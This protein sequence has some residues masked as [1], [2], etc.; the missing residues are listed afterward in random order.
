MTPF[1]KSGEKAFVDSNYVEM[2]CYTPGAEIRYT[3]DGTE[4]SHSSS[5]YTVPFYIHASTNFKIKAFNTG[6]ET[7]FTEVAS[8]LKLPYKRSIS[9]SYPYSHLY[10][11]GGSNGLIDGLHGEPEVFG[12]WQ[13]FFGDD[14]EAVIDLGEPRTFSEISSTYLQ[15]YLAWIWIPESVVYSISNNGVDFKEVYSE[16]GNVATEAPGSFIHKFNASIPSNTARYVK[17]TAKNIAKC[18]PWHPGAGEKAW[19]FVDEVVV[20]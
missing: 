17:I 8:F 3:I 13:G 2:K 9:Y 18:P 19:I 14:F 15:Q 7:S 11:A 6:M 20:K 12:G 16:K 4:P 1:L 5:L 10:T